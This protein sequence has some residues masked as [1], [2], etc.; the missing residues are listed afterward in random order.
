M[1]PRSVHP[2]ADPVCSPATIGRA[3]SD[4]HP[5]LGRLVRPHRQVESVGRRMPSAEVSPWGPRGVEA[6][7]LLQVAQRLQGLSLCPLLVRGG[8]PVP[9]ARHHEIEGQA[10]LPIGHDGRGE[11]RWGLRLQ[12]G[13]LRCV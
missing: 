13:A 11:G 8:R 6:Q 3:H 1:G 4:L 12:Q 7:V 5:W 10:S 2:S 9:G